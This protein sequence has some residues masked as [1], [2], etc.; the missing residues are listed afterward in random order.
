MSFYRVDLGWDSGGQ[1]L[2]D[3]HS[4]HFCGNAPTRDSSM[5]S[6]SLYH[7]FDFNL[8]FDEDSSDKDIGRE[9][10]SGMDRVF[11]TFI[12]RREVKTG[13]ERCARV[14]IPKLPQNNHNF[15]SDHRSFMVNTYTKFHDS[16]EEAIQ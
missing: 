2:E 13:R 8:P 4:I 6:P 3:I 14:G 15:F 10:A 1:V 11:W 12:G 9:M 16:V 5:R 7:C